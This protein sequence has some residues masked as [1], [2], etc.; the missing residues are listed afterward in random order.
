MAEMEIAQQCSPPNRRTPSAPG[1]W[2][3]PTLGKGDMAI[4]ITKDAVEVR[5][6]QE[7]AEARSHSK[8]AAFSHCRISPKQIRFKNKKLGTGWM[9]FQDEQQNKALVLCADPFAHTPVSA[10]IVTEAVAPSRSDPKSTVFY[11]SVLEFLETQD[12]LDLL[13]KT[14]SKKEQSQQCSPPNHRTPS[15]P[16]VGGR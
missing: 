12:T 16:V 11:R 10:W 2:W 3:L 1:G 14:P 7:L 6:R 15:A 5:V 9:C 8:Y 13:E 4:P